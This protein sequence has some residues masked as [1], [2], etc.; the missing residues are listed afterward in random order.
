MRQKYVAFMSVGN[1][2]LVVSFSRETEFEEYM[3]RN[4]E[5]RWGY[6]IKKETGYLEASIIN[7]CVLKKKTRGDRK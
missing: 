5:V 7:P 2:T 4:R 3:E 1:G 6:L